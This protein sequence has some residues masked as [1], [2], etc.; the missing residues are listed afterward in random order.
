MMTL[1]HAAITLASMAAGLLYTSCDGYFRATP[2]S[3]ESGVSVRTPEVLDIP[4]PRRS[5]NS[6]IGTLM[7]EDGRIIYL[8]DTNG[9]G[10][11]DHAREGYRRW[12]IEPES[13]G[14]SAVTGSYSYLESKIAYRDPG[15]GNR[16]AADWIKAMGLDMVGD[17]SGVSAPI[18]IHQIQTSDWFVDLTVP[19][20]SECKRASFSEFDLIY[21]WDVLEDIN[22]PDFEIWRVAGD[23]TE[24]FRFVKSCGITQLSSQTPDGLLEIEYMSGEGA[25]RI[26]LD[27]DVI[28]WIDID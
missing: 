14:P 3:L 12:E 28:Q 19:A 24:A 8:H 27:D 21:Q 20:T 17:E 6:V 9:D 13:S 5:Y 1:T 25:F 7:L 22:G 2:F 23:I 15:F 26:T 11:P 16:S 18:W 10:I 4:S